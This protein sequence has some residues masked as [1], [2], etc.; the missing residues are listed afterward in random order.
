MCR[1]IH[2][3]WFIIGLYVCQSILQ[4][5]SWSFNSLLE[6][7]KWKQNIGT[8]GILE[9]IQGRGTLKGFISSKHTP[10]QLVI[11][12]LSWGGPRGHFHGT[13]RCIVWILHTFKHTHLFCCWT[14]PTCW[15]VL[16]TSPPAS[17]LKSLFVHSNT[18]IWLVHFILQLLLF[19]L[20]LTLQSH[21]GPQECL[22]QNW[23]SS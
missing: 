23:R 14:L 5:G 19:G 13:L 10:G 4:W 20:Q 21:S 22:L 9:Q 7:K 11:S 12:A 16:R 17:A 15:T 2:I 1:Q 8:L 6:D 18:T 3:N